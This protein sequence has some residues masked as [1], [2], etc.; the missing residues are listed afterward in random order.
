MCWR[1]WTGILTAAVL[2]LGAVGTAAGSDDGECAQ[3]VAD[4]KKGCRWLIEEGRDFPCSFYLGQASSHGVVKGDRHDRICKQYLEGL[5][6]DIEEAKTEKTKH[7]CP[8]LAKQVLKVCVEPLGREAIPS[9][10]RSWAKFVVDAGPAK[11]WRCNSE[12][13]EIK[14]ETA[15]DGS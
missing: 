9:E 10:C 4:I 5:A 2:F 3:F 11:E 12:L 15:D 1:N 8:E 6:E 13:K 7:D 14:E